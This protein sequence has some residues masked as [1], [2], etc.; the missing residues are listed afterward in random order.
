LVVTTVSLEVPDDLLAVLPGGPAGAG[1]E[2]CLAA[3]LHWCRRGELSTSWA[4]RLAGMTYADFIEEAA[5]RKFELFPV[6]LGE[7]KEELA[8]PR[9]VRADVEKIKE[10]LA[11]AQSNRN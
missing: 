6:D 11:R 10:E 8:R 9:P 7:L 2:L 1:R 4:A 5:R 3:A